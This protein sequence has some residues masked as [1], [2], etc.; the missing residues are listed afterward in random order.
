MNSCHSFDFL[1]LEMVALSEYFLTHKR[2]T[3]LSNLCKLK[4]LIYS[5]LTQ[6]FLKVVV[7]A[8]QT[9]MSIK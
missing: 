6:R 3:A 5:K 9:F 1:K 8:T 4:E 2:L 7:Q